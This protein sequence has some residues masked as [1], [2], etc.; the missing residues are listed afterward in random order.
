MK[1]NARNLYSEHFTRNHLPGTYS[2][3]NLALVL[4]V[5]GLRRARHGHRRCC[6]CG[7]DEFGPT[8]PVRDVRLGP[9]LALRDVR[10]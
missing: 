8:R 6:E 3:A 1:S 9:T 5:W 7:T 10:Y 4:G 2:T